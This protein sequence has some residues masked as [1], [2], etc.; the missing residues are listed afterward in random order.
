LGT[1]SLGLLETKEPRKI[2]IE[3]AGPARDTDTFDIALPP[4]YKVDDLPPP[5]D[6]DFDFASYRSKS[7]L[8]GNVIPYTR[9]FE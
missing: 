7:E 1:K 5:V 8:Q 6:A 2:P 3:F 4:G 9:V